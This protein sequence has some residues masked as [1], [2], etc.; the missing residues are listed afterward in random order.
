[1]SNRVGE[2]LRAGWSASL[3]LT[4]P[5]RSFVVTYDGDDDPYGRVLTFWSD[6]S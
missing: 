3:S 1:M 4:F 6:R 2:A 5:E